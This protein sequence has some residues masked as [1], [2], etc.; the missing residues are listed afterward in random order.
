MPSSSGQLSTA[1][2]IIVVLWFDGMISGVVSPYLLSLLIFHMVADCLSVSA[3][4]LC[5]QHIFHC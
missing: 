5:H 3:S 1:V 2:R 4:T